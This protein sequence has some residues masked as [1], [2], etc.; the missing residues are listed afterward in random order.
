MPSNFTWDTHE[1]RKTLDALVK[2]LVPAWKD[3]LRQS[4]DDVICRILD[5]KEVVYC[6]ATGGG[7][8]AAFMVPILVHQYLYGRENV[9]PGVWKKKVRQYP[10]GL[11]VTP[12]KGLAG[13]IVCS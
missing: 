5:G 1:G 11:V 6:T 13:N 2:H 4:Q 3:G 8:S 9:L 12:T 10:V 7:K